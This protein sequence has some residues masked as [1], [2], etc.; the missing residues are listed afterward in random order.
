MSSHDTES[1]PY[2][3]IQ[4]KFWQFISSIIKYLVQLEL[5]DA[6]LAMITVDKIYN[7]NNRDRQQ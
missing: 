5:L 1:F 3:A 2:E 7:N 6:I 4:G